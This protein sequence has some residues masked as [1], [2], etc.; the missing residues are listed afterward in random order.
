MSTILMPTRKRSWG[1][2]DAVHDALWN[3]E[4]GDPHSEMVID[5]YSGNTFLGKILAKSSDYGFD[6]VELEW[7]GIAET[8]AQVQE[9]CKKE[10]KP[11]LLV[12]T[13]GS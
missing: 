5:G 3:G 11:K 12:I 2:D 8:A 4:I 10:A 13:V 9:A 1:V 6:D 7:E